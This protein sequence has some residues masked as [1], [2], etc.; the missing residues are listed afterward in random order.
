MPVLK[1]IVKLAE[2]VA[3]ACAVAFV[4]LLFAH[5]PAKRAA[6]VG[7]YGGGGPGPAVYKQF[8]SSCHGARG[9]GGVGPRLGGGQ[10]VRRYPKVADHIEV[11]TGGRGS[12]PAF[13]GTL[14]ADQI[15]A[16]VDFERTGLG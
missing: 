14:T 9:E 16:V 15:R 6:S 3:L 11:V 1:R 13:R 10:V 8:C 7:P 4:V 2:L 5:E 12:M